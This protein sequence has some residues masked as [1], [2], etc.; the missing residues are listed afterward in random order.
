MAPSHII[1]Y[2]SQEHD[3]EIVANLDKFNKAIAQGIK[4]KDHNG[5]SFS[6][7]AKYEKCP[8]QFYFS[9]IEKI[10]IND[11]SDTTTSSARTIGKIIH[12]TAEYAINSLVKEGRHKPIE[13]L[14]RH[15]QEVGPTSNLSKQSQSQI[16]QMLETFYRFY[17]SIDRTAV[18]EAEIHGKTPSGNAFFGKVDLVMTQGVTWKLLDLKTG[19]DK[20]HGDIFDDLMQAKIYAGMIARH[21]LFNFKEYTSHEFGLFYLKTEQMKTFLYNEKSI[22]EALSKFDSWITKIRSATEFPKNSAKNPLCAYCDY[23]PVCQSKATTLK[24]HIQ[25]KKAA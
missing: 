25:A 18:S 1:A 13:D 20:M 19:S 4:E 17:L 16:N 5:W 22:E 21:G 15:Y 3:E 24:D 9:Y 11:K 2:N 8:A 10:S 6:S 12:S 23:Q 14:V 7:I